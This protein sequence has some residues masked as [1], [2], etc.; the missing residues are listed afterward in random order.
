MPS[1]TLTCTAGSWSAWCPLGIPRVLFKVA[2][3]PSSPQPVLVCGDFPVQVQ[4]F[5]LPLDEFY[6]ISVSLLKSFWMTA[7]PLG[8]SIIL[9]SFESCENL[10][11]VY[12]VPS[13][14]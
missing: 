11:K 8:V 7:Q 1:L 6:N 5:A 10:L 9:P 14:K 12:S 13:S 2:F 4:G 3:K